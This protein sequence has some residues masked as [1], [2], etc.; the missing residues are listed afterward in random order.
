[1][2]ASLNSK[3]KQTFIL[4]SPASLIRKEHN[5]GRASIEYVVR[6]HLLGRNIFLEPSELHHLHHPLRG[7]FFRVKNLGLKVMRIA[8]MTVNALMALITMVIETRSPKSRAPLN[9][10]AMRITN[11]NARASAL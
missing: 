2:G 1:M 6:D 8:G 7:P 11:P 9:D 10:E 5:R 4:P 3:Y